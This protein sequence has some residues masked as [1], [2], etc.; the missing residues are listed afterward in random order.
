MNLIKN[1]IE[2]KRLLLAWQ[3]D[4]ASDKSR[5]RRVVAELRKTK[6]GTIGFHYLTDTDD[7][8]KAVQ[9]GLKEY[10]HFFPEKDY[11]TNQ[12]PP[13]ISNFLRRIPSRK[14]SDFQIFLKSIRIDPTVDISDFALLGYS[15]ALLPSDSFSLIHPFDNADKPCELL[16]EATGFRYHEGM[17]MDIKIGA[18]V[19]LLFEPE[20]LFDALAIKIEYEGKT[21]GYI[22][23]TLLNAFHNWLNNWKVSGEIEKII[24]RG[25]KPKVMVFI[26]VEAVE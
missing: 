20:N 10:P 16:I 15:G 9:S 13:F 6:S 5:K 14:R 24:T 17:N 4:I 18:P 25:I 21:I 12:I 7:F 19:T 23:R 3:P 26:R 2:P 8:I 22:N 11:S 1:I